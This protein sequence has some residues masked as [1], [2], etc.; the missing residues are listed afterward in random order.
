MFRAVQT[1][2]GLFS[3]DFCFRG[4][5]SI[6]AG[7][8]FAKVK[9]ML[10]RTRSW[11]HLLL[12]VIAIACICPLVQAGTF[13]VDSRREITAMKLKV[14]AAQFLNRATFGATPEAVEELATRM[15]RIGIRRA[16][17]E[18]IDQQ[19]DIPATNHRDLTV[20]MIQRD[21]LTTR[22][23]QAYITRYRHHSWWHAAL[24]GEDQLR[25]RTAWALSQILVTSSD[26]AGF[27]DRGAGHYSGEGRWLGPTHYYDL[28]V[29]HAF[30]SYEE[31]LTDV[32]YHPVM[33][34]YLSHLRNRKTNLGENRFP[35]ENYAREIMQLFTIGLYELHQ[36]GRLKTDDNGEL[37]PTYT[38]E[39]IKEFAKIFTGLSFRPHPNATG[40]GR[41]WWGNDFE[42]PM[43]M[44]DFEHEPGVKTL[45]NGEVVGSESEVDG[46]ADIAAAIDNLM[47]HDNVGPFLARRLIQRFVKSNP[48]RAYIRRVA[49]R[50][51]NN[52]AGVKGDMKAVIK[53]ILLDAEAWRGLSLRGRS[54]P[55]RLEVEARGTDYSKLQE[56]VIRY[57][58]MLR[59]MDPLSEHESGRMM[60]M[61]MSYNWG[62]E[63]YQSPTVFNFF[64]PDYQAPALLGY[65]PSR[66]IPN[67][68]LASPE[69]QV[70]TPVTANRLAGRYIWDISSQ[71]SWQR[72]SNSSSGISHNSD[73][74]FQLEDQ[75]ELCTEDDDMHGLM[76]ELDLVLCNGTMP[77]DV[78]EL[79]VQVTAQETQWM[80]NNA[81]WRPR[82]EEFRC[83]A[84]LINTLTSPFAAVV[85]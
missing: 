33:G 29:K 23:D 34:I 61:P 45:L 4:P 17:N 39:D 83:N 60:L 72:W 20:D 8:V 84:L 2:S 36:D 14:R 6:D 31:L 55:N 21:G 52:G 40:N 79:M 67:G 62:Q 57:T 35:D 38:N 44:F 22:Q 27:N 48:S 63:P 85:E 28:M 19:F 68:F 69:F 70:E 74:H 13:E 71:R 32:T 47:A 54:G 49:R 42:E 82:M 7:Q 25:Q 51:D 59:Y 16:C 81:F 53:A 66:R 10:F 65:T 43:Q 75:M 30:G 80:K 1:P 58:S 26:G 73:L 50:F 64:L 41:F 77:Q 18:W 76:D 3:S 46:N 11:H 5:A 56:P 12:C 9:V 37:I 24:A 78:K 15:R